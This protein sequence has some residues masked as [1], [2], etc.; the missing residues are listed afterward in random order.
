MQRFENKKNDYVDDSHVHSRYGQYVHCT[1]GGI[2][3]LQ[4]IVNP[5]RDTQNQ[6]NRDGP[7]IFRGNE[8]AKLFYRPGTGE[9][10]IVN[11][12]PS[13]SGPEEVYIFSLNKM[14]ERNILITKKRSEVKFSR[15]SRGV[16]CLR[17][18]FHQNPVTIMPVSY[19][20]IFAGHVKQQFSPAGF[21]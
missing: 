18:P 5:I 8:F 19:R 3:I 21:P 11:E 16:Y 4:V 6:G 20:Q 17:A 13:L 15:V 10:R 1:T 7:F 12:S 14:L 2:G 9:V